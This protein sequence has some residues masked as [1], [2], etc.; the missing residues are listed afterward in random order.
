[1][2]NLHTYLHPGV[3]GMQIRHLPPL[4]RF[5]SL[6]C[7]NLHRICA[8]KFEANPFFRLLISEQFTNAQRFHS[9]FGENPFFLAELCLFERR[10]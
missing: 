5:Y 1:M 4:L 2:P 10:V 7:T 9:C 6:V 3:K 8:S